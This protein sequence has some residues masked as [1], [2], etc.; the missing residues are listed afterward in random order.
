MQDTAILSGGQKGGL[1]TTR[2]ICH[3]EID[4]RLRPDADNLAMSIDHIIP[5]WLSG[6]TTAHNIRPTHKVCNNTRD[7]TIH[8]D[9]MRLRTMWRRWAEYTQVV[10]YIP[11]NRMRVLLAMRRNRTSA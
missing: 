5:R 4:L 11:I 7:V 1:G 2:A 9:Q 6:K 8:R 3:G 10:S